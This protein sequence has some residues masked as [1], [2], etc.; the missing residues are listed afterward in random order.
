MAKGSKWL[1]PTQKR[2]QAVAYG[3]YLPDDEPNPLDYDRDGERVE[4]EREREARQE[5]RAIVEG[6]KRTTK[7][8]AYVGKWIPRG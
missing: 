5:A 4:I 1:R 3:C 2:P 6:I 7:G 8:R